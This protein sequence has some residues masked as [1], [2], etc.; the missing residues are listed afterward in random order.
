MAYYVIKVYQNWKI[1][2]SYDVIKWYNMEIV[3]KLY[4]V[5]VFQRV[6]H[7][8]TRIDDNML[9]C[10]FRCCIRCNI[11]EIDKNREH[12]HAVTKLQRSNENNVGIK[13]TLFNKKNLRSNKPKFF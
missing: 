7:I 11:Q 3:I 13:E 4:V 6:I 8:Y 9:K 2:F 12:M 10:V 5:W 1:G